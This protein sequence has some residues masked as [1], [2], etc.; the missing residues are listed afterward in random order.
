MSLVIYIYIYSAKF[1]CP[2]II[3]IASDREFFIVIIIIVDIKLH[4][5]R[6]RPDEC[7]NDVSEYIESQYKKIYKVRLAQVTK[8]TTSEQGDCV[9]YKTPNTIDILDE[10]VN[11]LI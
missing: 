3:Y 4:G 6:I 9:P 1:P 10:E 2:S 8:R 7:V 11:I 5:S